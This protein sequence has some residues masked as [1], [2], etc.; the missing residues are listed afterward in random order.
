MG[1]STS[2]SKFVPKKW[3]NRT[4]QILVKQSD[5]DFLT[6][7]AAEIESYESYLLKDDGY[8]LVDGQ[9]PIFQDYDNK[10]QA[11]LTAIRSDNTQTS[12]SNSSV[13]PIADSEFSTID[14]STPSISFP[15]E[16]KQ[17][18]EKRSNYTHPH[19]SWMQQKYMEQQNLYHDRGNW[20]SMYMAQRDLPPRYIFRSALSFNPATGNYEKILLRIEFNS[21]VVFENET[22]HLTPES[23]RKISH[24]AFPDKKKIPSLI[25]PLSEVCVMEKDEDY[26]TLRELSRRGMTKKKRGDISSVMVPYQIETF[27]P[28]L[29]TRPRKDFSWSA[30]RK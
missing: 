23:V 15:D 12:V 14:A 28:S 19:K 18:S 5:Y 11:T 1:S 30:Y 27:K 21:I 9:L 22:S 7:W 25:F 3:S 2:K 10:L 20:C 17:L 13:C 26:D 6:T 24:M 16:E 4:C 8:R 29:A